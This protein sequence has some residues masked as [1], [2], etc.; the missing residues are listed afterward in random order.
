MTELDRAALRDALAG[1]FAPLIERGEVDLVPEEDGS[2]LELQADAWTFHCDGWPLAVAWIALDTEPE[3]DAQRR[4]ALVSTFGHGE[5]EAFRAA[6]DAT[7]AALAQ[8]LRASDDPLSLTLATLL[9]DPT[10][11]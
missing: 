9:D 1:A 2:A 7:H 8:A 11:T 10:P 4:D 3:T 5:L 6:D